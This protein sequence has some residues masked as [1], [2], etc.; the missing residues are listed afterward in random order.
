MKSPFVTPESAAFKLQAQDLQTLKPGTEVYG[1]VVDALLLILS[2]SFQKKGKKVFVLPETFFSECYQDLTLEACVPMDF[3]DI[4]VLLAAVYHQRHWIPIYVDIT[5]GTVFYLDPMYD[6]IS[7]R[8]KQLDIHKVN[9]TIWYRI[10]NEDRDSEPPKV[11]QPW[12][13][14]TTKEFAHIIGYTLPKQTRGLDCGICVVMYAF[15]LMYDCIFDFEC[16]AMNQLRKWCIAALLVYS[17]HPQVKI[18][19]DWMMEKVESDRPWSLPINRK[20]HS[21]STSATST[22]G[23]KNPKCPKVSTVINDVVSADIVGEHAKD[24]TKWLNKN[25]GTMKGKVWNPD[26]MTKSREDHS[27]FWENLGRLTGLGLGDP[28]RD[29]DNFFNHAW[30][31]QFTNID[32]LKRFLDHCLDQKKLILFAELC[33]N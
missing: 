33:C 16:D 27:E 20:R 26:A 25:R 24:A 31:F 19:I 6:Y 9:C 7:Q 1:Q 5:T 22:D 21:D 23:E 15:Y 30:S 11:I 32:D 29:D 4:D 17:V 8:R 10:L 28:C 12:T 18:Q 13:Y 2:A 14:V 3:V